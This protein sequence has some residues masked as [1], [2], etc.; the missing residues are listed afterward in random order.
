ML[1]GLITA[2]RTLTV[3]PVP[4][5]DA[6][7]FSAAL[8]GFVWVGGMLGGLMV[9]VAWLFQKAGGRSWP[10]AG[11]LFLLLLGVFLTRGLHLDGVGD[12]A[13]GFLG[14]H[15]RERILEIMKDSMLGT[16]GVTALLLLL[17]GK[18]IFLVRLLE[19]GG[20]L[21]LF[22]AVVI[23]RVL[24]VDMSVRLPYARRQGTA[25]AFVKGATYRHWILNFV[26][27]AVVLFVVIGW[28]G[29]IALAGGWLFCCLF[30]YA[31]R[32]RIGG[33]TGDLLGACCELSETAV[34]LF[35]SLV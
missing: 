4:G 19:E 32:K 17:L 13:D 12:C 16:F 28:L 6:R 21:W 8:Y 33:V 20:E 29:L 9:G 18:W 31:A 30:G 5:R 22:A 25:S 35:G 23:S 27:A 11:A 26:P 1:N 14:G 10:E 7:D 2:V 15:D 24:M 34:I 3:I